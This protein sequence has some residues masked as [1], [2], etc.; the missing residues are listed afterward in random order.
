MVERARKA[1]LAVN[2]MMLSQAK[3]QN[4]DVRWKANVLE[5]GNA[6][7]IGSPATT[8][9]YTLRSVVCGIGPPRPG[10]WA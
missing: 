1:K 5:E 3:P 9:V 4:L 10:D 7:H 8:R 2:M 6:K